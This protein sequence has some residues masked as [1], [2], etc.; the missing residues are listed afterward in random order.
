MVGVFFTIFFD[1]HL[2]DLKP[3]PSIPLIAYRAVARKVGLSP[4][5]FTTAPPV[6]TGTIPL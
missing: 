6:R 4:F 2:S 5:L 1:G 3:T